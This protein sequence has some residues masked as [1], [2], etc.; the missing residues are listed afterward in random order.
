MYHQ[1]KKTFHVLVLVLAFL[2]TWFCLPSFSQPYGNE[3]ID[4]SQPYF[5]FSVAQSGV[6]RLSYATIDQAVQ[7]FGISA[8]NIPVD[9]FQV[10]GRGEEQ[11]LHIETGPDGVFNAGD[12]LEFYARRNDGWFDQDL[13]ENPSD[14]INLLTS[15]YTDTASY[16]LT[17]NASGNGRRMT[18]ENNI[19]FQGYSPL[20]YVWSETT[21]HYAET[22]LGGYRYGTSDPDITLGDPAYTGGE[23]WSGNKI[24]IN[25]NQIRNLSAEGLY[26]A[27]PP[28]LVTFRAVGGSNR[29]P[30]TQ[31]HHFRAM[32][33]SSILV[34]TSWSYFQPVT[35]SR[36][37]SNS[38]LQDGLNSLIFSN[39]EVPGQNAQE[40]TSLSSVAVRFP[41][42]PAFQG[43]TDALFSVPEVSGPD[44]Q[45]LQMQVSL[46][47]GD[48]I[49]IFDLTNHSMIRTVSDNAS[50]RFLVRNLQGEE[51]CFFTSDVNIPF[52]SHL[53]PVDSVTARFVNYNDP[54][55]NQDV[56]YLII[57]HQSLMTQALE[58][59]DYREN[60]GFPETYHSMVLDI[61]QLYDQFGYGIQKDPLC[62]RNFLRYAKDYFPVA[63]GFL[64]L[65][66]KSFQAA[67]YR[68]NTEKWKYT[69]VPTFGYPPSDNMLTFG[70]DLQ[71]QMG[72]PVGRLSTV[73]PSEVQSYLG[74]V[75]AFEAARKIP[76]EMHKQV[77][78]FGGGNSFMEQSL[79]KD[80]ILS[81]DT[82]FK[83]PYTGCQ[84]KNFFKTG[85]D[86]IQV[87]QSEYLHNIIENQGVSLINY[88]G[89]ASGINFDM[90]I[91]DPAAYHNE[92]KYYFVLGN[93]CWAGDVF[94]Y[95]GGLSSE[96]YVLLPHQGAIGYL[97]SVTEA[98]HPLLNKF[99]R[100]LVS[101]FTGPDYDLPLGNM[102]R[103][104]A[105]LIFQD[106]IG[107]AFYNRE[108]CLEMQLHGDPALVMGP[109]PLPD[110][111]MTPSTLYP[112]KITFSPSFIT[113]ALDS[114][115]LF[116]RPQNRGKALDTL[117][118][119][120]IQ[121]DAN[122]IQLHDTL[123]RT[124]AP[125]YDTVIQ[126][127]FP[128]DRLKGAGLNHFK[129]TLD[130]LHEIDE[131]DFED[132]NTWE[133]DLLIQ[134]SDIVP[135]YPPGFAVVPDT[136]ISLS[137][138]VTGVF[139]PEADYILQLDTIP[140]FDSP[141]MKDTLIRQAG[142]TLTWI[143]TL[144]VTVDSTVFYWRCGKQPTG[145]D[146]MRFTASSF[147]FIPGKKG[148]GQARFYQM[149]DN[150]F[151]YMDLDP[152]SLTFSFVQDFRSLIAQTFNTG[153]A[154][155]EE[156]FSVDE[157]ILDVWSCANNRCSGG[158]GMKFAVF[159]PV[160]F[161]PWVSY[162][163]G[164]GL[165]PFGNRHCKDYI[166]AAY[167]FCN[168]DSIERQNITDFLQSI[169]LGFYVLGMSHKNHHAESYEESVYQAFESIG[170]QDVRQIKDSSA[171]I[172]FGVKGGAMGSALEMG[173]EAAGDSLLHLQHAV[174]TRWD[175]GWMASPWI[176][177]SA[178]WD[179]IHW[180]VKVDQNDSVRLNVLG[181]TKK[182]RIDTLMQGISP[183]EG[184]IDQLEQLFS[185][186]EY[187]YLRLVM[188]VKDTSTSVSEP[189]D[190]A[191]LQR[192][193]VLYEEV[194]ETSLDPSSAF[195]F[196]KENLPEGDTLRLTV[197]CRNIGQSDMDSLLIRYL[198]RQGELVNTAVTRR[199]RPHPAG[200]VLIDS[201]RFPTREMSGDYQCWVEVNPFN[202]QVE[203]THLNNLG[204]IPFRVN[205]DQVAPWMLVSF[206]KVC[207]SDFDYVSPDAG[208]EIILRDDNP[209]LPLDDTSLIQVFLAYE[210]EAEQEIHYST[211]V[212]DGLLFFPAEEG[213]MQ[214]RVSYSPGFSRDGWYTLRVKGSDK[215]GNVAGVTDYLIHFM[216]SHS[217]QHSE[218]FAWPNPFSEYTHFVF[219]L[220]GD[221]LPSSYNINIYDLAGRC[222]RILDQ[223]EL[224]TP[225]IGS[226]TSEIPWDGT[227]E[228]GHP[229]PGG[230]YL[231][232][233]LMSFPNE[234]SQC[235]NNLETKSLH[236]GGLGHG[237]IIIMR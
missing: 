25:Q 228:H 127:R 11:Y 76:S 216:V 172:I 210:S 208:I 27:G 109:G 90:S 132:N 237:K 24:W 54:Q 118:F 191:V 166:V 15:L 115:S 164:N 37:V 163:V 141:V 112:D 231:F 158:T 154:W 81:Y 159:D 104:T 34:D 79:F 85:A 7:P 136:A 186:G 211:V 180:Q 57:T 229:L 4:Y 94:D 31:E 122:G 227:D 56:N 50:V 176:G 205:T 214:C 43:I 236:F 83:G 70:L 222:V 198:V 212:S 17:W 117:F 61:S 178:K 74:K 45:M 156:Y 91:G 167:D 103:N 225:H 96:R 235:N 75:A 173:T 63:P 234:D 144:P 131:G 2:N 30:V 150:E 66:G 89:H 47:A 123:I 9:H 155:Q 38:L 201:I 157:H 113:T 209:Y 218:V 148:W 107:I 13:Y 58:Y 18:L 183:Q 130:A 111:D 221:E 140:S 182:G 49:R 52:I 16:Y 224:G 78:Q 126:V 190:P 60:Y 32:L 77:L 82:L 174:E 116:I 149:K 108:V 20:P 5:R 125:L 179:A 51:D 119:I 187:P 1:N 80:Y 138:S 120:R 53:V 40:W 213:G 22:F 219:I 65:I 98:E 223:K 161:E 137:A 28:S 204:L 181:R 88:F 100:H 71:G 152:D 64:F 230:L 206:D 35:F 192:W 202:D 133:S 226:N 170:S 6:Y 14:Q 101:R 39:I 162:P 121:H 135:V 146:T 46:T 203:Q 220:T 33:G 92:D 36:L 72:I 41:R 21:Q 23:G 42:T 87:A 169:P 171:Y 73:D 62:I 160:S 19:S 124:K 114:F 110:Y 195:N 93:S 134:S 165:G 10:W 233:V 200:D 217:D 69:L 196:Y 193:Q 68:I 145:S 105:D 139:S 12:F 67:D 184:S 147:Q 3:W 95:H 168:N 194:P 86:P 129:I 232:Q 151:Q 143:C 55:I 197:S 177:P 26:T 84:V 8:S 175:Q 128:V 99:T 59:A 215:S 153:H 188:A 106:T 199:L 29:A 48:S 97:A 189:R 102:I 207:I 142:G 44:Y 185:A